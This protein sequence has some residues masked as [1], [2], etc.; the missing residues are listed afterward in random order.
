[1]SFDQTR[2]IET[3]QRTIRKLH[4]VV[5]RQRQAIGDALT[6][7]RAGHSQQAI[8]DLERGIGAK[9]G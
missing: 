6:M 5:E 3:Q 8:T 9:R 4:V 7:L 2:T 1:M